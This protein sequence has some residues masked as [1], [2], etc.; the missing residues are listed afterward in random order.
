MGDGLGL[1][2]VQAQGRVADSVGKAKSPSCN[3][4]Q[5]GIQR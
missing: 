4:K 5:S 2:E 3:A 1:L